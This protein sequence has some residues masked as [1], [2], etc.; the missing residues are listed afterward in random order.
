ML[1]LFFL[2]HFVS[3]GI[4]STKYLAFACSAWMHHSSPKLEP[5]LKDRQQVKCSSKLTSLPELSSQMDMVV[6]V[7]TFRYS[8]FQCK[9]PTSN[10]LFHRHRKQLILF[11]EALS[12]TALLATLVVMFVKYLY[13]SRHCEST[14]IQK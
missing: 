9:D 14:R 12:N 5:V 13:V 10:N 6:T 2:R 7:A 4:S 1:M 11:F 8:F 3:Q